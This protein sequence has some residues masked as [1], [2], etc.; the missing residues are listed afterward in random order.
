MLNRLF[1]H[2]AGEADNFLDAYYHGAGRNPFTLGHQQTVTVT[3]NSILKLGPN[4]WQV[5]WEEQP[6]DHIGAPL[7]SLPVYRSESTCRAMR[8]SYLLP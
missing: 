3:V 2:S 5:R 4:S 7:G 8:L 1:E 6:F